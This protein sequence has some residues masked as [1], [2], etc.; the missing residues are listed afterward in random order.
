M[1]GVDMTGERED[2]DTIRSVTELEPLV[3]NNGSLTDIEIS[4]I[5]STE[6]LAE[7]IN[8][9]EDST[10]ETSAI[11]GRDAF[12]PVRSVTEFVSDEQIADECPLLTKD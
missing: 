6:E 8:E 9:G 12:D 11:E 4:P 10:S 2:F 7:E 5:R 1:G 3:Y